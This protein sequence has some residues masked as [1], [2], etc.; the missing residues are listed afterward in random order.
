MLQ[1]CDHP[2]NIEYILSIHHSR[3][4]DTIA[5]DAAT[6][7]SHWGKWAAIINPGADTNVSQINFSI[8]HCESPILMGIMDDLFP[9]PHWDTILLNL[10]GSDLNKEQV[11]Q[12]STCSPADPIL[13]VHGALTRSYYQRYGYLLWP[14]YEGMFA[15][16]EFTA[17]LERDHVLTRRFDIVFEHVHPAFNK[18]QTDS[19]YNKHWDSHYR[20]KE[21]FER[22][23][24]K[25]FPASPLPGESVH[26]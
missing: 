26:A 19:V 14:E 25:G 21:I 1:S 4:S 10:F 2:E 17:Q 11:F 15:D 22:R 8:S 3:W 18:A 20:G 6:S 7:L 16:N 13:F 23:R 9:P 24:A 12:F 5:L